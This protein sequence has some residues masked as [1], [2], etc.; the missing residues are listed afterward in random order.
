M[1]VIRVRPVVRLR[2]ALHVAFGLGL[3]AAGGAQVTTQR[4]AL[5]T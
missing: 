2:L 3:A 5:S 4:P 1:Q